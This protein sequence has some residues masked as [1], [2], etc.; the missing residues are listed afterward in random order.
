M[1]EAT[2]TVID[3]LA[4]AL[5]RAGAHDDAVEAAPCCVLW[6]DAEREWEPAVQLLA[7]K[8]EVLTLGDFDAA[9]SRGPAIWIRSRVDLAQSAEV[10]P[11]VVYLPG[12]ERSALRSAVDLPQDLLPLLELQYRGA[13]FAHRNGRDWT[14]LAFLSAT[15]RGGLGIPV[16]DDA[17]TRKALLAARER[18][19]HQPL[20]RL[21]GEAPLKASFFNDLLAPDVVAD[22]LTWINDEATFNETRDEDARRAFAER[23]RARLG[24]DVGE[25]TLAAA[26]RLGDADTDAW[27]RGWLRYEQ[28]PTAYPGIE[29]RLR[30]ARPKKATGSGLIFDRPGTWPQDNEDDEHR[31]RDALAA[32]KDTPATDARERVLALEAEHG[33]R[34]DWVWAK[35]GQSPLAGSLG[36]L[37][38]VARGTKTL[39]AGTLAQQI[40]SYVDIGWRTDDA[41]LMA[42][43]A[44]ATAADSAAVEAAARAVYGDWLEA[45]AEAVPGCRPR[46][47]CREHT[48]RL[49]GVHVSHLSGR[50]AP[51]HRARAC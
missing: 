35:L 51:G 28:A 24:F 10:A 49:A 11:P 44:V 33:A 48:A 18:L 17:L 8:L 43:G 14:L 22:V 41:V 46:S 31:L 1:N 40:D 2:P 23:V 13:V 21:Q 5:R 6:P 3:G 32:L 16:V 19:F 29:D 9:A 37:A 47:L 26:R 20:D 38:E 50:D 36:H 39:P 42:L 34:R 7:A 27:R 25:G 12:V 15:D 30:S 4:R 45:S